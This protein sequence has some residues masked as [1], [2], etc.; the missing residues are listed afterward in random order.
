MSLVILYHFQPY[1]LSRKGIMGAVT[2]VCDHHLHDVE[3]G[4][5]KRKGIEIIDSLSDVG[6]QFDETYLD[7]KWR[8]SPIKCNEIFHKFVTED[9][10]CY[11]FN[12]LSP[13]EIF[14]AEG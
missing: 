5:E 6:P 3:F 1:L 9:G 8:N 14:R 13:A 2:Q 4:S 12:S 11:S 10:V 7:C